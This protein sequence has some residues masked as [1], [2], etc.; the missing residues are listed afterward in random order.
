MALRAM[1][2]TIQNT[3]SKRSAVAHESVIGPSR[4]SQNPPPTGNL[5]APIRIPCSAITNSTPVRTSRSSSF[6]S[7][8]MRSCTVSGGD[9]VGDM[10]AAAPTADF[11]GD[12]D[13][14]GGGDD[15]YS[16]SLI[17]VMTTAGRVRDL[18]E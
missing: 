16:S 4:S 3:A 18:G 17:C 7:R 11:D 8:S 15:G 9:E 14:V 12:G 6:S 1:A 10:F 5:N 13:A 2:V